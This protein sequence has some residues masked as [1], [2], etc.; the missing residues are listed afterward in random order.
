MLKGAKLSTPNGTYRYHLYRIW[1]E[2]LPKVIF[3]GLNP[4]TADAEKDDATI[5][6]IIRF[7]QDW[8]YGGFFIVNLF[9]YRSRNPDNLK[10]AKNPVGDHN[11][12]W[13]L[14]LTWKGN[15]VVVCWGRNGTL[16]GR[17]KEVLGMLPKKNTYYME[18]TKTGIPK[19]PLYLPKDCKLKPY[20]HR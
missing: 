16:Y 20:F 7:C 9:A 19:H 15:P 18:L 5:R 4:S 2:K 13:I 14:R 11:D 17:D 6:R 10:L 3:I 8:G 1:N 12:A